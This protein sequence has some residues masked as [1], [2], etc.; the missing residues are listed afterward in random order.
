MQTERKNRQGAR[1]GRS[2][3]HATLEQLRL[4][5]FERVEAGQ[6]IA[7]VARTL[8]FDAAVVSRWISR[9]RR[10]G[11]QALHAKPIP[12][13]PPSLDDRQVGL[14]RELILQIPASFW[15]FASELWTRAMVGHVI[16]RVFGVELSERAVGQ[17]MR[18]RM[19]LTPQRPVRRAFECD[20]EWGR[21]WTEEEYPRIRAR[22]DK[23]G[24]TIYF[25]DEACDRAPATSSGLRLHHGSS[26]STRH[27]VLRDRWHLRGSPGSCPFKQGSAALSPPASEPATPVVGARHRAH[28]ALDR[29]VVDLDPTVPDVPGQRRPTVQRVVDRPGDRRLSRPARQHRSHQPRRW[30]APAPPSPGAPD[31][32]PRPARPRPQPGGELRWIGG[33]TTLASTIVTAER[34]ASRCLRSARCAA[35]WILSGPGE[36]A[37]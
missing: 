37:G 22:A 1:D 34:S 18:H 27:R 4:R 6:S 24:A 29:V 23:L 7:S 2:L 14:I 13:R 35:G 26:S 36:T 11:A 15:G 28:L 33:G 8:G 17:I 20:E 9:A 10:E 25:A 12:G 16:E 3:D 30:R 19:G 31:G 5:A 21:Q 32:A